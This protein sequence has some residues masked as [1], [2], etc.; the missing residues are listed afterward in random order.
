MNDIYPLVSIIIPVYNSEDYLDACLLSVIE[1]T[2]K[3]LEII[4]VND[5]STD[6]S[7]SVIDKFRQRDERVY[8]INKSNEGLPLARKAGIDHAH[9][10]YIQH[11]DSDDILLRTAI[12][13]LVCRAEE[14]NA[15][16][17]AAPFYFCYQDKPA[18]KSVDLGF[19]ELS[20]FEYYCEI[21]HERAYWSVWSNFQKRSLFQKNI[22]QTI[23]EISFGED[24]ILM[25]QLILCADKVV[26][27]SEPIL[28]YNRYS[29]AMS[30]Q[31]NK[32]R[33]NEFRAYQTWLEDFLKSKELY[34]CVEKEMAIMHLKTTFLSISWR[35]LGNVKQDMRRVIVSLG[36]F[37]ELRERMSKEELKIVSYYRISPLLGYMKLKYY[38]KKNRV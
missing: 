5:G 28:K 6:N 20:G 31:V 29:T 2:Y 9:G 22:I 7:M 17:V 10:K 1:Q 21:L 23:P 32:S 34:C 19:D 3:S 8:C 36:L 26:S 38:C 25:T 12:E 33:Y 27:L 30:L 11:L 15:D 4:V 24:A 16:I 13:K 14:T 35:R 37:P 18:E